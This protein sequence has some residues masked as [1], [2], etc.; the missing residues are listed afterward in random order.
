MKPSIIV[1]LAGTNGNMEKRLTLTMD[2]LDAQSATTFFDATYTSIET[3][4]KNA[5]I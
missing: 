2:D 1:A 3:A 5:T 4:T